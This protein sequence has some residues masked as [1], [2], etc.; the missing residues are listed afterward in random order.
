[1]EA[2][3]TAKRK[4]RPNSTSN[5]KTPH[6]VAVP[7]WYCISIISSSSSSSITWGCWGRPDT[8][9]SSPEPLM[10][11]LSRHTGD[12]EAERQRVMEWL[13]VFTQMTTAWLTATHHYFDVLRQVFGASHQEIWES[14]LYERQTDRQTSD[15][16]TAGF[17]QRSASR[18]HRRME[19]FPTASFKSDTVFP[20]NNLHSIVSGV[21]FNVSAY[22]AVWPKSPDV[23]LFVADTPKKNINWPLNENIHTDL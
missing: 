3:L 14:C 4:R 16:Q 5:H 20:N 17:S 13:S 2:T 21:T 11:N 6:H 1:M 9:A 10:L 12:G 18:N 15:R 7:V 19:L 8:A 22:T 23:N